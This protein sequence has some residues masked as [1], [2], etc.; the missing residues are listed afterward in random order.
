VTVNKSI[1]SP[2]IQASGGSKAEIS[3]FAVDDA[4]LE[5]TNA[6][7]HGAGNRDVPLTALT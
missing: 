1:S 7:G 4:D 6:L 5:T 2:G 3:V